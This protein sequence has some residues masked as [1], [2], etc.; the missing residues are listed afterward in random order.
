MEAELGLQFEQVT[1]GD[2]IHN[3]LMALSISSGNR[4]TPGILMN[5]GGANG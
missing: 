1:L 4:D 2:K 3:H 5:P